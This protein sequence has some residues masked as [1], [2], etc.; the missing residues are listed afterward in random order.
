ME[1]TV[2]SCAVD[3]LKRPRPLQKVRDKLYER[4]FWLQADESKIRWNSSSKHKSEAFIRIG[5]IKD[6]R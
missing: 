6:V 5:D 4:Q 1:L 2:E 3:L